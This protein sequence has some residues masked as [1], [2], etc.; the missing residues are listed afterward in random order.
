MKKCYIVTEY[1][2]EWEDKWESILGVYMSKESAEK[3]KLENEKSHSYTSPYSDEYFDTLMEEVDNY[4]FEHDFNFDSYRD[5]VLQIHPE[6]A[7]QPGF[8]ENLDVWEHN[9]CGFPDYFGT[10]ISE[11]DLYE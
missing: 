3:A 4:E 5:G 9:Y 2:G 11:H 1:G 6:L 8:L 7:E 10:S